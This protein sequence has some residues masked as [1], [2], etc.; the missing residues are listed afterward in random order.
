[1]NEGD[2]QLIVMARY[3]TPG[4][5][6]TRLIHALGCVGAALLQ[7]DMTRHLLEVATAAASS[8]DLTVE[9]RTTGATVAKMR[10]LHGEPIACRDQG[11]G[12]LGDR[13]QRAV[14]AAFERGARRVLVVGTDCPGITA[15][16]LLRAA[17][18]LADADVVLGPAADGG[19]Y[20]LGLRQPAPELLNGMPWGT[21][22]LLAATLAAAR[23][24]RLQVVQ[25][26]VLSDVDRPGDLSA[27]RQATFRGSRV[28]MPSRLAITGASG[29][30]GTR[31][32][33]YA[34]QR[35]PELRITALVRPG[36]QPRHRAAWRRLLAQHGQ[37]IE[38]CD[39]DLQSET[40]LD[41]HLGRRLAGADGGLWHFA[42][43][44]DLCA[45]DSVA[46]SALW[47]VNDGGTG[48]MLQL[49]SGLDAP[50]PLFHISTAYVCGRRVGRVYEETLDDRL[51]FRNAYEA[52]KWSAEVRVRQ[53]FGQGLQGAIL[54]PA[55]VVDALAPLRAAGKIVERIG[56]AIAAAVRQ[57][58]SELVLRVPAGAAIN[59]VHGDWVAQAMLAL[60]GASDGRTYHLTARR[61][62]PLMALADTVHRLVPALRLCFAP[63]AAADQLRGVSRVADR[64]LAP[65]SDYLAAGPQLDFERANL[66]QR[67][68]AVAEADTLDLDALI[69]ARLSTATAGR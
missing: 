55:V 65:M 49:L 45:A 25:L 26:P 62:L 33:H 50:P 35:W 2:T 13:V 41:A 32:L 46:S 15:E 3:P 23:Q 9:L 53:A 21:G 30:L 56:E 64:S 27:W 68:G 63:T 47:A 39:V 31:F 66:E 19:Y 4:A 40:V 58:Q 59:V 16:L 67:A 34:M 14:A 5:V 20:L 37:R 69:R 48:R 6:K 36:R 38:V 22:N 1:M 51:G 10:Q 12:D 24:Q 52:S 60:V 42:A 7:H 29:S 57:R 44:T 54:R 11:D 61:P 8:G 28:A 17:A 43:R 18:A